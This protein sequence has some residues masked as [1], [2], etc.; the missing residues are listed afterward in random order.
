MFQGILVDETFIPFGLS[1]S[2]IFNLSI[3]L[4]IYIILAALTVC[5]NASYYHMRPV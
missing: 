4:H 3:W 1:L 5:E 2:K